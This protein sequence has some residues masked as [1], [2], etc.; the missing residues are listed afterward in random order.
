MAC[1]VCKFKKINLSIQVKDFEY[2]INKSATYKQC[3]SC[4]SLYRTNPKS[5]INLKNKH[6]PKKKYLPLTGSIFYDFFKSVYAKYEKRIILNTIKFKY[7]NKKFIILDIACG[8][9]FLIKR[10]SKNSKFMCFGTDLN[11][12]SRKADKVTFIKSKYNNLLLIKKLKPD[13][14]IMNN[15]IEHIEN[16]KDIN[17]IIACMKKNSALAIITPDAGSHGRSFFNSHWSGY[18]APR[19][20]V[21]F[22]T[23]GIRKLFSKNKKITFSQVKIYDPFTNLM[24]IFNL[25][26]DPNYNFLIS[27]LIKILSSFLYTFYNLK[28]K[29]KILFIG[30]K[31]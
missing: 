19:H 12:K 25:L 1:P 2:D 26:K 5:L 17:N 30:K 29:N 6:Y 10:F 18:H 16:Y 20:K 31:F 15:F 24:S 11:I 3:K 23:K 27:K 8:K 9:G 14:I 21:I 22:T 13:L 28:T 4:H 7:F